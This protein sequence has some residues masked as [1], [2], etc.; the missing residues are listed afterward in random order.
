MTALTTVAEMR[1]LAKQLQIKG[2]SSM[3][4]ADLAKAID[5]YYAELDKNQEA[6][7]RYMSLAKR[8]MVYRRTRNGGK[9]TA[10]QN[11][12]LNKKSRKHE[13]HNWS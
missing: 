1:T 8:H 5:D 12:R 10:R 6:M 2:Y 3:K 9:L 13:G 7:P 4:K 11:R